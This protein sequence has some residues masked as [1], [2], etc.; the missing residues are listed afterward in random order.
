MKKFLPLFLAL[1]FPLPFTEIS[2]RATGDSEAPLEE[3]R[4]AFVEASVVS[5]APDEDVTWKFIEYSDYGRANDVLLLQLYMAVHLPD[6]EVQRLLDAYDWENGCW[7][8]IDYTAQD[9]G[10]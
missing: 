4:K 5:Y 2:A 9:R 8:D 1:V 3:V 7:T 10:R 6:S